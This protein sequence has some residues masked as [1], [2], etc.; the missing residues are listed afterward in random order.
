VVGRVAIVYRGAALL[1]FGASAAAAA[2][3]GCGCGCRGRRS[4]ALK[5]RWM[6]AALEE[7][8]WPGL[9]RWLVGGCLDRRVAVLLGPGIGLDRGRRRDGLR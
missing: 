6:E 9:A 5:P 8:R 1:S 3:S 2:P 7:D 4:W